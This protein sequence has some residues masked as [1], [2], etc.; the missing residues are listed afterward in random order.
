VRRHVTNR[1]ADVVAVGSAEEAL[2]RLPE[3]RPDVVVCDIGM[4]GRDGY[5]LIGSVRA[6]AGRA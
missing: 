5:S 4:P 6:S 1:H 2:A 3:A